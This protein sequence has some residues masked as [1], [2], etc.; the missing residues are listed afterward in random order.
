MV[1][2]VLSAYALLRCRCSVEG[3]DGRQDLDFLVAERRGFEAVWWLHG[4]QREQLQKMVLE[5]VAEDPGAVVI[6]ASLAHVHVFGRRNLHVAHVIAIPDRLENGV[7]KSKDEDVL[8]RLFAQVMVNTVDLI[9]AAHGVQLAVERPRRVEVAPERLFHDQPPPSTAPGSQTGFAHRR[10]QVAIDGRRHGEV[11]EAAGPLGL[12]FGQPL[13][14]PTQ[15]AGVVIFRLCVVEML[16]KLLPFSRFGRRTR[17]A[18]ALAKMLPEALVA[19]PG[20]RRSDDTK[21]GRQP[22]ILVEAEQRRNQLAP[23]QVAGSAEDDDGRGI[24]IHT[25]SSLL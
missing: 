22:P 10:D 15:S 9:L 12:Q 11:I 13:V 4:D 20:T 23:G 16:G 5:H 19:E 17:A 24:L 2:F 1:T 14:K 25:L 7:G 3:P 18:N 6:A 21:I 8:N